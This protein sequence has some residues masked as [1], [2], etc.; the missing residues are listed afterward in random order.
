MKIKR[1]VVKEMQ[2]AI[3]LI[4]QDLGPEAVIVS[5]YKVPA[6]GLAGLFAPRLLE[7][8]A[9]LD[10]SPE[11][12]LLV[13]CPPAQMAVGAGRTAE[14][15]IGPARGP[16]R[17]LLAG[18]QG[19]CSGG[20]LPGL[21]GNSRHG[22]P[23]GAGLLSREKE[24]TGA[25]PALPAAG[26]KERREEEVRCLF[27]MMVNR[28]MEEGVGGE[29]ASVWRQKLLDLDIQGKIVDRLLSEVGVEEPPADQAH[30]YF[31]LGLIRQ[32][33]RLLEPVYRTGNG[34]RVLSF[35]GPPGVGKTTTLAKLAAKA[36]LYQH[37]RV[38]L[39]TVYTY[40]IGAMDQLQ[41]YGDFLGIPVE[42]VMTPAE[43]AGVL[44]KHTDKDYI[45]IDTNG[46]SPR[47]AGQI[48]ELKGF[49]DVV[50]EP[51][52]VFLVL[53]SAMKNRD[54]ARNAG[55]FQKAGFTKL[56]F[57]KLD[58][59]ETLGSI[60]NLVNALGVPAAYLANGQGVPDDII[61]ACPRTIAKLL[62]RGVDPD[63]VVA[64]RIRT[65]LPGNSC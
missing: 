55:E 46:R 50:R 13:D 3:R 22:S 21:T 44:E 40:R 14:R 4:R 8:T 5:S 26:K 48:L 31:Y 38:A 49:L 16:V 51:Q 54:L 52:E 6:R 58:E 28:E 1:Y 57:T 47:K 36:S 25:G 30:Q 61:E 33:S 20:A 18:G 42:V 39:V 2:E 19:D 15:Q 43:L 27:E 64:A 11:V 59:T 10:S 63:E 23:S 32:V 24:E 41:A 12:E 62:F 56:I 29:P 60:L 35:I 45:F 37:K 34:A 53:D 7:V 9:A 65:D 17:A